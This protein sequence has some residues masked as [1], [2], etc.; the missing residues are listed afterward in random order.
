[1]VPRWRRRLNALREE[2]E[3]DIAELVDKTT[4]LASQAGITREQWIERNNEK[5]FREAREWRQKMAVRSMKSLGDED[6]ES[7]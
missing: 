2:R 5:A 3:K 1:M 7:H 4:D 6:D